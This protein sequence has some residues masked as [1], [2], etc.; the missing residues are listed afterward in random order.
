MKATFVR[1]FG[2]FSGSGEIEAVAVDDELGFVYYADE[3]AGIHK[4]HADPDAAGADRELALFGTTGFQRDREG[5]GI[6][7]GEGGRGFILVV[8]QLPGSSVVHVYRREGEAG[9]PHDHSRE[10]ATLAT[11]AD[12]TDGLDVVSSALGSEFPDG[13]MVMMNSTSKNFLLFPWRDLHRF[14]DSK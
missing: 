6:Y 10:I 7:T 12:G 5:I 11:G 4:W 9:R 8:D 1:R 2:N 13:L 3:G 14:L